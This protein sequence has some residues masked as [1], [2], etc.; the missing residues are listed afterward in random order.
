MSFDVSVYLFFHFVC[1][2]KTKR[3]HASIQISIAVRPSALGEL[4]V[5]LLKMLTNTRNKVIRRAILPVK[6]NTSD[7][8]RQCWVPG[9]MSGGIRK[10]IHETATNRPEGR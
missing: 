1:L 5:M 9:T 10:E 2:P 8:K 6:N 4:V 3:I 7:Y